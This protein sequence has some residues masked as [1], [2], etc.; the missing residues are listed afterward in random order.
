[1]L[2]QEKCIKLF[3]VTGGWKNGAGRGG[4]PFDSFENA[5]LVDNGD[6]T[7]F[8]LLLSA[9]GGSKTLKLYIGKKGFDA[10]GNI[11]G[12]ESF[13]ARNGVLYGEWHYLGNVSGSSRTRSG[14]LVTDETKALLADKFGEL[15]PIH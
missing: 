12:N 13:L 11:V 7:H 10:N 5:A 15:T 3:G 8:A 4:M 6:S 9:D 2:P 1:M 14:A